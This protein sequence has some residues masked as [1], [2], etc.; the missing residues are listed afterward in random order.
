[1]KVQEDMF[2]GVWIANKEK[3]DLD[4]NHR[5]Q[6]ARMELR[7]TAEGYEL[8]AE[9]RGPEGE[10]CVDAATIVLDS[11][12]HAV[13]A[14]HGV[15]TTARLADA[16]RIEVQ[17]RQD[18]R[19]IGEASYEVSPDGGTLTAETWGTDTKGRAFRTRVVFER[20]KSAGSG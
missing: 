18:E 6:Q 7:R 19:V 11:A 2:D 14:M 13:A 20:G 17:G 10:P 15:T 12:P 9:G 1:M 4:P 16:R 3:S 8:R 5:F